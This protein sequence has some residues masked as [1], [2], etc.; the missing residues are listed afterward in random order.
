MSRDTEERMPMESR[1]LTRSH[2]RPIHPFPAR[3]APEIALNGIEDLEPGSTILD[4]MVGSGTVVRSVAEYG[5]RALGFDTDPLA[6]LMAR[7][8]TTPID[9]ADLRMAAADI[10]AR[11]AKIHDTPRLEWIDEDPDTAAFVDYWFANTQQSNLRRIASLL[12]TWVDAPAIADALRIALSR[13]IITK[14]YGASLARDV[15]H[16]RPHRTGITNDFDVLMQFYR[17]AHYVA[18]RLEDSPPRAGVSV[19]TGDARC[20]PGVGARTVDA[21]VTSPPYLNAIDYMRG[22]RFSLVWMG[23][24]LAPLR[25]IRAESIGAERAPSMK[26]STALVADVRAAMDLDGALPTRESAMVD[27]YVLDLLDVTT[28]VA[29]VLRSGGRAIF[30]VGNS[31]V[32]GV[33]VR[34]TRAVAAAAAHAGLTLVSESERELPGQHRYLPPPSS[35]PETAVQRR[36]RTETILTFRRPRS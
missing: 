21:V 2:I 22:H 25:R 35:V 13:I 3:M 18:Q 30:V 28:E 12:S 24:Q 11:A 31:T 7:V 34:N 27:R 20:L 26:G 23:Y 29:R 6:V 9:P 36:M 8:W 16:S 17:S 5:H 4:P 15:S 10:A 32:R 33:F 14:D 1:I 19:S